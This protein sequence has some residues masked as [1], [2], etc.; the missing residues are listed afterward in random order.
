[1]IFPVIPCHI[2]RST[3]A[4][5]PFAAPS[6]GSGPARCLVTA[7]DSFSSF[8]TCMARFQAVTPERR[9]CLPVAAGLRRQPPYFHKC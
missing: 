3:A 7:I 1:M 8:P 9:E 5:V 6:P 4:T 2:P